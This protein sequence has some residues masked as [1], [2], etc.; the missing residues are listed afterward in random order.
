MSLLEVK[1]LN[2]NLG[3]F[4]LRDVSLTV[5]KNNYLTIIGPTGAGKSV[6]LEVIA[7]FYPIK[8]GKITLAG[9][10]ITALP[11]ENRGMS[12]VYQDF[13][14]FP[15][16]NVFDNIAFGLRKKALSR[17]EIERE[18]RTISRELRI[19]QL[20]HRKPKTLS[21][22]EQQRV[23]IARALV[24]RPKMLLMDE[25]FSALDEK[26]R[27]KLRS[28]V[29]KAV[30]DYSTTVIH[31]THDFEDVFSLAN[32][33]AVMKDGRIVQEGTPEEIFCKPTSDFVA[34]F[35]GTNF[36]H[37]R[38]LESSNI[39]TI[40]I[41][42]IAIYTTEVA[43][44]GAEVTLSVRPEAII[45]TRELGM[46]SARNVLPARVVKVKKR[47]HVLWLTLDV[48][49]L[50]LRAVITLNAAELLGIKEG[51]KL[52]IMFKASSVRVIG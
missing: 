42:N 29:K 52:Y 2:I 10:N 34:D 11:P 16:L 33:V 28:M 41:G 7:G 39:T 45:L 46:Y 20:L 9:R 19:D 1:D 36:F 32:R 17:A 49:G 23:A 27:E 15:H 13:M 35:V 6:L 12:I 47:G 3:E 43:E 51:V 21:G 37:G 24:I 18:V 25:P 40:S 31:V 30:K 44:P 26:T 14:L 5:E 50:T 22:G 4:H 48:E 38:V 8:S